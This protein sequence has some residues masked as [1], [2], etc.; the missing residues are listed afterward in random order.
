MGAQPCFFQREKWWRLY[1]MKI[2][3]KDKDQI[4]PEFD[5]L[6]FL[7][8]TMHMELFWWDLWLQGKFLW[9]ACKFLASLPF[10]LGCQGRMGSWQQ[11]DE[12]QMLALK[13]VWEWYLHTHHKGW[14][15]GDLL[16]RRQPLSSIGQENRVYHHRFIYRSLYMFLQGYQFPLELAFWLWHGSKEDPCTCESILVPQISWNHVPGEKP[17]VDAWKGTFQ[18]HQT[19]CRRTNPL[20]KSFR[21]AQFSQCK[22]FL[23]QAWILRTG[24]QSEVFD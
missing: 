1:S 24:S 16:Y 15:P 2:I 3:L 12:K 17:M 13:A 9:Q 18:C 20:W 22:L 5:F 11:R 19:L 21:E 8:A 14:Y 4:C 10:W 23:Q 7:E 6:D